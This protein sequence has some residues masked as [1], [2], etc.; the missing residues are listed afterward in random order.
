MTKKKIFIPI[1][2]AIFTPFIVLFTIVFPIYKHYSPHLAYLLG[3]NKTTTYLV[4]LGNDTEVR[5]N[6][7]F[8]GSYAKITIKTPKIEI[9]KIINL[10]LLRKTEITFSFHDIYVP[11]GQV[12]GYIKP[13]DAIQQAFGKGSWD[14]SNADYDPNFPTTATTIRWFLEKGKETNPDVLSIINLSTIKKITDIVGNIQIPENNTTITSENLYLYLQG[15]AEVNFFPGSTQKADAL[16]SVGTATIKK[17]KSLSLPKKLQI[18]K[19]IYQDLKNQNIVLNSTNQELQQFLEQQKLAGTYHTDTYDYYG[20][21]E[22]NLGANKANQYVTRQT[23]HTVTATT[24]SLKHEVTIDL[25]NNSPEK[26]PNPPFHYG[27]HYLGFFRIYL[28]LTATDIKFSHTEYLP[29]AEKNNDYC[30]QATI[31]ANINQ[32][33][34]ER[35]SHTITQNP[36]HNIISF[37]HLTLAGQHSNIIM[38]YNLP[39]INLKE[40]TL[41][42]LK[43]NGFPS[44]PQDLTVFDKTYQT[45]LEQTFT[46]PN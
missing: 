14:L 34:L 36:P 16:H 40:Y 9:K 1:I 32:T 15:K 13:P 29:C 30:Y 5:A 42:I 7:G 20:L 10:D 39:P 41:T 12:S 3:Q 33:I 43:Q 18:S 27:G 44:S 23:K 31:S 4:L 26:N 25:Q 6:G 35:Q 46:L 21:V 24:N 28:P 11:S 2:I 17:I 45:N 37:W 8:A 19:I 38:S 22:L